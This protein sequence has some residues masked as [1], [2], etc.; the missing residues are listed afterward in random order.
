M[1]GHI[2][3][4]TGD[5]STSV[6][7]FFKGLIDKTFT[8]EDINENKQYGTAP[9]KKDLH[10]LTFNDAKGTVKDIQTELR[11]GRNT[12]Q[13]LRHFGSISLSP[14]RKVPV[15]GCISPNTINIRCWFW[16]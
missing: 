14:G 7:G 4:T 15:P 2:Y 3:I 8:F 6:Y 5:L 10:I 13:A 12:T 16:Y 1:K 9:A 11:Y